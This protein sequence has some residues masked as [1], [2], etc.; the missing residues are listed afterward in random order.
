ML[1]RSYWFRFWRIEILGCFDDLKV[2]LNVDYSNML[3]LHFFGCKHQLK[4]NLPPCK[5][6]ELQFTISN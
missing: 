5:S 6:F 4:Y 2:T 1:E 3:Y